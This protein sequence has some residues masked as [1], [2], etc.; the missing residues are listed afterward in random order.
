MCWSWYVQIVST[1]L[2]NC[3]ACN[4]TVLRF[5]FS[6][7]D[8]CMVSDFLYK[9]YEKYYYSLGGIDALRLC[10]VGLVRMLGHKEENCLLC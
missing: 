3:L 8:I 2:N 9:K 6:I 10:G 1:R 5:P 4:K 7:E